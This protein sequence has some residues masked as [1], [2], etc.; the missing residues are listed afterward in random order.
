MARLSTV[1]PC[2]TLAWPSR[3]I[4]KARGTTRLTA[5]KHSREK[6][7]RAMLRSKLWNLWSM[8]PARMLSPSTSM[9]LPMI[10][11]TMLASTRPYRPVLTAKKPMKSSGMLP[12]V[13]LT[14]PPTLGPA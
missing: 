6:W 5:A 13:A 3:V 8:P 2:S 10:E 1:S 11:P 14:R 7:L 9:M 4:L 12:M